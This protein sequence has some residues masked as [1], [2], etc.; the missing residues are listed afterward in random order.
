MYL[1]HAD[2]RREAV[3][4]RAYLPARPTHTSQRAG[5]EFR[6]IVLARENAIP[7]PQPL[8]LDAEAEY[9]DAPSMLLAYIPGRPV[10]VPDRIE[11]WAEQLASA[12]ATIHA[13]EPG[14]TDLSWLPRMG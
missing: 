13:V 3:V 7:A 6:T 12:M 4:L 9:L 14:H 10:F 2:G 8:F 1:E 11:P 5:R